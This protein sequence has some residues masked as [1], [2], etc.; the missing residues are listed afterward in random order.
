MLE[1]FA[2]KLAA[3]EPPAEEGDEEGDDDGGGLDESNL[4]VI[5]PELLNTAGGGPVNANEVNSAV[6]GQFTYK[7]F[8]TVDELFEYT[9]QVGYGWDPEIPSVCFAISVTENESK[10]KYEVEWLYRD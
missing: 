7:E 5:D 6:L 9:Q 10:N 2:A 3:K 1:E 8:E 4:F